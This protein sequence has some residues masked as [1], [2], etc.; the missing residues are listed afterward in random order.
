VAKE[1]ARSS[2]GFIVEVVTV[3]AELRTEALVGLWL[4]RDTLTKTR[5]IAL[6]P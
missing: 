4:V 2:S 5:A 3:E 6:L 1:A